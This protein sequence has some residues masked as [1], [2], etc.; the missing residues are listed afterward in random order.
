MK[1]CPRL[2]LAAVI[3]LIGSAAPVRAGILESFLHPDLQ[4]IV[5]TDMT[6]AGRLQR[7]PTPEHPSYYV[8]VSAGYRDFGGI[9]AGE[10]PIPRAKLNQTVMKVLAKRGYLPADGQ[11]QP[12]IFILW[13]WGTLNMIW[14]PNTTLT[15]DVQVNEPRMRWFLGGAKLGVSN[16]LEGSFPEYG[17]APE[18]HF[19]GGYA[20]D[21]I[22]TARQNLYVAVVAAY[23]VDLPNRLSQ[24]LWQTRISAP[25]R[26]FWMT[27]ALPAM[28][29]IAEPYFGRDTAQPVWIEASE[30]FKPDI[31]IGDPKVLDYV[32]KHAVAVDVGPSK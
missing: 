15:M 5:V 19:R 26:G 10:R 13:T 20:Q 14:M 23:T 32:E 8:A 22:D 29:A 7:Q 16:W 2:L 3:A 11:H 4:T 17:L 28:V 25:A 30:K 9:I 21:L 6:S 1:T 18:L 31:R 24:L 27:E 12:D